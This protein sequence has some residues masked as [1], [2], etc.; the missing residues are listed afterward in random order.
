MPKVP[1]MIYA[2]LESLLKKEQSCQ[3]NPENS[4]TQR[5]TKHEPSDYAL[6]SNCSFDETKN[7]RKSCRRKDC[8][9]KFCNDLKEV[10][11]EVIN[12]K[13][14]EMIPLTDNE[15]KSYENQKACHICKGEFCY[16]RDKESKFKIYHKVRD[17]CHYTR[18]F[19]S[20]AH[21]ICNLR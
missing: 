9:K 3:N 4:H 13:E 20:V 21:N 6:S 8:I 15:I 17:H 19:R 5:K 14:K 1:F 11:T 16:D 12:C 7:R 2:D 10:T 18:K